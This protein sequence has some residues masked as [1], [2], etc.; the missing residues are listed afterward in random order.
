MTNPSAEAVSFVQRLG[1]QETGN[2]ITSQD[3]NRFQVRVLH[4]VGKLRADV[5]SPQL[6]PMAL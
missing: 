3:D 5:V 1:L 4:L 6:T 2:T